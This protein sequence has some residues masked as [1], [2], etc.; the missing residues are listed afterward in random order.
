M[1]FIVWLKKN[2]FSC[3]WANDLDPLFSVVLAGGGK[4]VPVVYDSHE[5]FTEAA[6]LTQAPI[7]RRIWLA[8]EKMTIPYLGRMITVNSSI[9]EKYSNRY[10]LKVDVVRNMPELSA[11][12]PQ[13]GSRSEFEAYGIPTDLPIMLMQGAFMDRDRGAAEAVNAVEQMEGVRLVL[14]GAGIEWE[15]ASQRTEEPSLKGKLYVS[16]TPNRTKKPLN[17]GMNLNGTPRKLHSLPINYSTLFTGL[18]IV[19]SLV[20]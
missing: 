20:K 9:A 7:K 5:Y 1:A 15:E 16:Q 19:A 18:P 8:V 4:G 12:I 10:G 3:I 6:G 14:V 13:M 17:D 11:D 2:E